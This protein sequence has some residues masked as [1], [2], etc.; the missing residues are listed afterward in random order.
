[1]HPPDRAAVAVRID[2][3]DAHGLADGEVGQGLTRAVAIG[4]AALGRVY[5]GQPD[6]ELPLRFV[7]QGQSFAIR[8]AH[9][10]ACDLGGRGGAICAA[11]N[12]ARPGQKPR[13]GRPHLRGRYCLLPEAV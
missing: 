12:S 4:L 2:H 3:H 5:L 6:P 9:Y 11:S 8:D 10:L 13:H 1:M 7:K